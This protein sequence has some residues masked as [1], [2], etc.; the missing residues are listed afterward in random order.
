MPINQINITFTVAQDT[1]INGAVTTVNTNFP[2]AI[3]L[4]QTERDSLPSIDNNRYAYVQRT[5]DM[6]VVTNPGL[7]SGF[8]GSITEAQN[9]WLLIKQIDGYTLK[10]QQIMEKMMDTRRLAVSELWNFFLEYYASVKRAA[11]N[12]I[13]GA[14]TIYND[15]KTLFEGQGPQGP[16]SPTTPPTPPTT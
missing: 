5:M 14:D 3:N 4:N 6:H 8:A 7:V 2:F 1:A 13:A 15:L 11:E 16:T 12:N 9:D 10:F